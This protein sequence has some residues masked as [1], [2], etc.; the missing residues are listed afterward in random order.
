MNDSFTQR[1]DPAGSSTR[2]NVFLGA[3]LETCHR[4]T[5][6]GVGRVSGAWTLGFGRAVSLLPGDEGMT[7]SRCA[8]AARC[9]PCRREATLRQAPE[10]SAVGAVTRVD[11]KHL[12]SSRMFSISRSPSLVN[13]YC[14][15]AART[16][17][18]Y[19]YKGKAAGGTHVRV[20]TLTQLS[21][22]ARQGWRCVTGLR[23]I[24]QHSATCI[25]PRFPHLHTSRWRFPSSV[26]VRRGR[27]GAGSP[28]RGT[29]P[30][31][32]PRTPRH[33]HQEALA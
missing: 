21:F 27:E 24:E 13:K 23:P 10:T 32:M 15:R 18:L 12:L 19:L 31:K 3:C 1:G 11:W 28:R 33:R 25:S 5:L 29:E 17:S 14:H 6:L 16:Q 7:G 30:S 2:S 22:R 8:W 4:H 20:W 26:T 9:W